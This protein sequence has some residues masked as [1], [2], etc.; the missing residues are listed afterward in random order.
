MRYLKITAGIIEYYFSTVKFTFTKLSKEREDQKQF[1]EKLIK[2]KK[3]REKLI[4]LQLR[5]LLK[6]KKFNQEESIIALS[7]A[8]V[9]KEGFT[10]KKFVNYIYAY[11]DYMQRINIMLKTMCKCIIIL[12]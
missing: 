6:E 12:R 3:F 9:M 1:A 4:R 8:S 11:E 10:D 2:K 5:V 7:E